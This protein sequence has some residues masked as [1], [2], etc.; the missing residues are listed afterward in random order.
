MLMTTAY[1]HN[2]HLVK[3]IQKGKPLLKT[4]LHSNVN[5]TKGTN[6]GYQ[7]EKSIELN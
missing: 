2:V 7:G 1:V 3:N 4:K 6:P 5:I